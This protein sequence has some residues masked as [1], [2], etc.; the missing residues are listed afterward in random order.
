LPPL[1]PAIKSLKRTRAGS[2]HAE[3]H[4]NAMKQPADRA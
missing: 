4:I 3:Y 1:S 2:R